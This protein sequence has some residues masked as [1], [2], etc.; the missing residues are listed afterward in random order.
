MVSEMA[1]PVAAPATK[2]TSTLLS[3]TASATSFGSIVE[4]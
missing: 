2:R 4:T 1:W 3:L